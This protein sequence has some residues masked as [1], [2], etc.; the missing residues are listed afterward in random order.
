MFCVSDLK[1]VGLF[2]AQQS[3]DS[4]RTP[5]GNKTRVLQQSAHPYQTAGLGA[6]EFMA[7]HK[8]T[9]VGKIFRKSL[10]QPVVLDF[11]QFS[12]E[13]KP[14]S[15][16]MLGLSGQCITS[17]IMKRFLLRLLEERCNLSSSC[18]LCF[19]DIP[20]AHDTGVCTLLESPQHVPYL[21][22]AAEHP[23]L[24]FSL[25]WAW[26]KGEPCSLVDAERC[27]LHSTNQLPTAQFWFVSRDFSVLGTAYSCFSQGLD[28]DPG[29]PSLRAACKDTRAGEPQLKAEDAPGSWRS[30]STIDTQR[31]QRLKLGCIPGVGLNVVS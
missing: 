6:A 12:L 21:G 27:L 29:C 3:V 26:Q 10:A 20:K 19:A 4:W 2:V 22:P 1:W 31:S 25:W 23:H 9:Q 16:E 28:W 8:V 24:P 30:P 15:M 7:Y 5:M 18:G 17:F 11:I 13:E 14:P